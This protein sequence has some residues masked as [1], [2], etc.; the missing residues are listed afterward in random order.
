MKIGYL[1][2]ISDFMLEQNNH[3]NYITTITTIILY[4][5]YYWDDSYYEIIVIINDGLRGSVGKSA[6]L[7]C[8]RSPV[9]LLVE[10]NLFRDEAK[11]EF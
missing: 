3:N 6:R 5:Y 1:K 9:Q 4:Y 8:Q 10:L 7:E 11:L 2:Y